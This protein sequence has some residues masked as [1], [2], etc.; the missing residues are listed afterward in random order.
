MILTDTAVRG[1]VVSLVCGI[2]AVTFV[3]LGIVFTVL[4]QTTDSTFTPIGLPF[5]GAGVVLVLLAVVFRRRGR[6]R[7]AAEAEARTSRTVVEIVEAVPNPYSRVG[8]RYPMR[9]DVALAGARYRRTLYVPFTCSWR[10][11]DR[12]EVAYAPDNPRNFV[13]V[14]A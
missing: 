3:P 11:G 10:P 2:V 14:A 12:I 6:R 13:P 1:F 8:A 4:G 5:L 7:D 9:L